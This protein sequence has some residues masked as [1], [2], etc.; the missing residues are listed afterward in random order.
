MRNAYRSDEEC[1]KAITHWVTYQ[2]GLWADRKQSARRDVSADSGGI[3][4]LFTRDVAHTGRANRALLSGVSLEERALEC[5][6]TEESG[7]GR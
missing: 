1:V 6:I 4:K 7:E 5:E 2:S 3:H